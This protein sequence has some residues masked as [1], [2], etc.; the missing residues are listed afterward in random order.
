M[1]HFI[2]YSMLLAALMVAGT[3]L[4]NTTTET[5]SIETTFESIHQQWAD[6]K[7]NEAEQALLALTQ[8]YP[9]FAEPWK[10]LFGLYLQQAR[11]QEAAQSMQ[12][13]ILYSEKPDAR[14]FVLIAY[15]YM[16]MGDHVAAKSMLEV[17]LRLAP[18]SEAAKVLLERANER[19]AQSN[20]PQHATASGK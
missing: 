3:G 6:G 19:L 20:T 13:A 9:S 18:Y 17:S 4:A 10:K 16:H 5:P 14:L 8:Q 2:R 11:Y 1:S 15:P 7:I 12:Q